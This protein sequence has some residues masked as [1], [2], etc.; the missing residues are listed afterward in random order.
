MVKNLNQFKTNV[1]LGQKVKVI[2]KI[3]NIVERRIIVHKQ[4][5]ALCTGVEI[6]KEEYQRKLYNW[7][8]C[9]KVIELDGKYYTKTYIDYPNA[10]NIRIDK[11]VVSFLA[12]ETRD[13]HNRKITIPSN[14]FLEGEAWLQ[15]I[16]SE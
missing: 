14:D 5:N 3:K 10:K 16:F 1:T 4:S 11:N 6:S 2:N 12:Y 7:L 15:M 9:N 8:D 13:S